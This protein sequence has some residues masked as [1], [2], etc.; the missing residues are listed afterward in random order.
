MKFSTFIKVVGNS[1]GETIFHIKPINKYF[2]IK[3]SYKRWNTYG[4]MFGNELRVYTPVILTKMGKDRIGIKFPLDNKA[5]RRKGTSF[6]RIPVPR[7]F[8]Y[9][10]K[11]NPRKLLE[12]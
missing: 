6:T 2:A 9:F 7:W 4:S 3:N 8:I 5:F 1:S 12:Y 11:E 10:D